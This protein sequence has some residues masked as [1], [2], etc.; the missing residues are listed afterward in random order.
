[1]RKKEAHLWVFEGKTPGAERRARDHG[2]LFLQ[3]RLFGKTTN[4]AGAAGDNAAYNARENETHLDI[5]GAEKEITA[6]C[7]VAYNA[8]EAATYAVRSHIIP[9]GPKEAEAWFREQERTDRKNARMSDRFI[10]ALPREL[11]PEQC[12]AAVESFCREVTQDRIPWHFALHLELEHKGEADWNPHTHIIF[13]DRDCETGRRFLHTSAGPKERPQL[14]A[15]GIHAWSTKD[16]RVAWNDTLNRELERAGSEA[17]VDHR[18]LKE[19]GIGRE[20]QIH[21]GPGSQNAAQK[22]HSFES[23]DKELADRA[24]P[25]SLMDSGTRA[26]HNARIVGIQPTSRTTASRGRV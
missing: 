13:R 8:R 7:N 2:H 6:A 19:Q 15:K 22:G 11:T 5:K 24:I 9:P 4:R 23:R 17:R 12:I 25:Y 3:P 10:A 20:P 16:L 14:E 21:I 26:E 18:S 1:M